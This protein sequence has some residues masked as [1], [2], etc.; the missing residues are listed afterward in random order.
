M[1]SPRSH[2]LKSHKYIEQIRLSINR[3]TKDKDENRVE[4]LPASKFLHQ[5]SNY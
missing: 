5:E 1:A 2:L 3:N 4:P